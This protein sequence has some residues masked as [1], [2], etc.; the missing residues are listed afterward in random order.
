M[1]EIKKETLIVLCSISELCKKQIHMTR[2]WDKKRNS[3]FISHVHDSLICMIQ[4]FK[5]RSNS[6]SGL[7]NLNIVINLFAV[8]MEKEIIIIIM[9]FSL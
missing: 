7:L 1:I 6:V 3:Q 4:N 8:E 5:K 9:S 2:A